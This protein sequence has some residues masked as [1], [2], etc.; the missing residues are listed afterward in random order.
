MT[1]LILLYSF[2]ILFSGRTLFSTCITGF[3]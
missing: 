1:R 2:I 3:V